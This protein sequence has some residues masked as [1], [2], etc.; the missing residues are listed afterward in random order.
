MKWNQIKFHQSN[1]SLSIFQ[2]TS[3]QQLLSKK[4]PIKIAIPGVQH[5]ILVSSAKGGVG[6]SSITV[7]LAFALR[8]LNTNNRVG[9]L[10]AD[11]FGPSIPRMLNLEDKKA[12][13]DRR[14]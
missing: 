9:I 11:V 2:K 14:E 3:Q 6:K 8:R 10:D 4:L 5:V 13:V 7:N 1:Q 12:D